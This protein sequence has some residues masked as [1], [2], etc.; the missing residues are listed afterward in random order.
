MQACSDFNPEDSLNQ[1]WLTVHVTL[2]SKRVFWE[3]DADGT[4]LSIWSQ[5]S[6]LWHGMCTTTV[7]RS[8]VSSC[9]PF[10][11][12]EHPP[13]SHKHA[14]FTIDWKRM[15]W[16]IS[17]VS[18]CQWLNIAPGVLRGRWWLA[19]WSQKLQR[20]WWYDHVGLWRYGS[21]AKGGSKSGGVNLLELLLPFSRKLLRNSRHLCKNGSAGAHIGNKPSVCLLATGAV[22]KYRQKLQYSQ[23]RWQTQRWALPR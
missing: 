3:L 9:N 6:I 8:W 20:L 14:Y 10:F 5:H 23:G 16:P 21:P 19:R 7:S 22:C 1:N 15:D 17:S 13:T 4:L 18:A 2:A 12:G 11:K